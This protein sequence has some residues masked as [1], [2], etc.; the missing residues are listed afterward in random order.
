MGKK[1]GFKGEVTDTRLLRAGSIGCGSHARRNVYT[2]LGYLPLEKAALCDLDAEK[3]RLFAKEFG[4]QKH[5]ANHLEMLEREKLDV[6]FIVTGYDEAGRPVYPKLAADCLAAGCHVWMEKPPA[7]EVEE[8]EALKTLAEKTGRQVMVG[9]KKMFFP[10]N[11]KAKELAGGNITTALLQYPQYLPDTAE[12]AGY[13]DK[14][15]VPGVQWFLDHICHPAS[16]MIY[17]M[18][19]PTH[20]QYVRNRVGGG[21]ANFIFPNGSVASIALT[22]GA[23]NNGGM[24]RTTLICGQGA[25]I[26]VDNNH[27]VSLHRG[28]PGLGYGDAPDFFLGN[29]G[30]VT[31]VWEPE[32]SLGQLYNGNLFLLG[33]YGEMREFCDAVLENRP[34]KKAHLD[35][36]IIVTKIFRAFA[37]GENKLIEIV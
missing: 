23:S 24:E 36:A 22:C 32:F 25:H 18:G 10:A 33:Y 13:F 4:Y 16:L 3:A 20:L 19:Y 35:D 14:K 5:Y 30:E 17:L 26:V 2:T 8:L 29:P 15:P 1:I 6:V 9:F 7:A 21:V 28:P 31:S 27:K 11:E 37:Q 12:F 34:L